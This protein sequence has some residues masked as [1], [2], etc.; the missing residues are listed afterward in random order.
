MKLKLLISALLFSL[1]ALA[2]PPTT[3]NHSSTMICKP[4]SINT[5]A[6]EFSPFLVKNKLFFVSNKSK[7][8][9]VNYVSND[10]V[11]EHTD[12]YE[13]E[14]VDSVTFKLVKK[15]NTFNTLNHDG[16]ITFNE[17]MSTALF[18]SN[19]KTN[20][21]YYKTEKK[22]RKLQLFYSHKVNGKWSKPQLHPINNPAYSFCH[23]VFLNSDS[24]IV[25]SSD[26]PGGYG[27]MDLYYAICKNN[28]WSKPINFGDKINSSENEIFP[29]VSSDGTLYFSSKSKSGT[30]LD[31]YEFNTIDSSI[32]QKIALP[33]PVNSSFDDF[34]LS[35]DS[36]NK[37]GYF[38]SNRNSANSDDI[39]YFENPIP[40]FNNCIPAKDKF[41]Y[42]FFEESTSNSDTTE[43][44]Y[45]WDLGD[46]T[47][48]R[49]IEAKHCYAKTGTYQVQLNVIEKASGQ[50]FY[51]ELSYD[52]VVEDPSGLKITLP[53]TLSKNQ[54]ISFDASSSKIKNHTIL[55]YYWFFSPTD[56]VSQIKA[57]KIYSSSGKQTIKLGV[58][59]LHDSTKVKSNF[60]TEKIIYISDLEKPK[61]TVDVDTVLATHAKSVYPN[62][63]KQ[64][65]IMYRVNL[66][67]S[68]DSISVKSTIF[69]GVKDLKVT[70]EDSIYRYTSGNERNLNGI[71]PYYKFAKTKG[72]TKA[73]VVGF[74]HGSI[75]KGQNKNSYTS[76][77]DTIQVSEDNCVIYFD[78][79][80]P[81]ILS[82][83]NEVISYYSKKITS[84]KAPRVYLINY[85]DGVG[86]LEYN[87]KLNNKRVVN[88]VS[89]LK[90]YK[91]NSNDI[92]IER[93]YY[94]QQ[95][96][97]PDLLRRIELK[98]VHNEH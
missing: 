72:F 65:S 38:S 4:I 21:F 80:K 58:V 45:E 25:F 16:P 86:S 76:V 28:I 19:N 23:P 73:V 67:V 43:T 59:A 50:L 87:I 44:I 83:Y 89:M 94:P 22:D 77:V 98:I 8:F 39:F 37:K 47:K 96:L 88:L 27:K 35:L 79:D 69:E 97:A 18:S 61:S 3:S 9:S 33:S 1:F 81:E 29:Y 5:S 30:D 51:N 31:I 40:E 12:I 85:F 52:F 63:V 26:I 7:S 56:V 71:L 36:T 34:G 49:G 93:I 10:S 11:A 57:N 74:E 24:V 92:Y 90:K 95:N 14:K 17:K 15:S 42:T 82:K 41:C 46:G 60:C 53:D 84:Y 20:E 13:C 32:F 78:Y 75:I 48:K 6:Q 70:H 54:L 68:R 2:Q 64:D 55:N 66:G 62:V 91:V